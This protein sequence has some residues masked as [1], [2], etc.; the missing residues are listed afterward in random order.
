MMKGNAGQAGGKRSIEET[1]ISIFSLIS[2]CFGSVA[3][4]VGGL[5]FLL[6]VKVT[7][8]AQLSKMGV[9]LEAA[10]PLDRRIWTALFSIAMT[11]MCLVGKQRNI[12]RINR[13][14]P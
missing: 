2:E 1:D 6:I 5:L 3:G 4:F 10:I 9:I 7:F 13:K 14:Q 11:T 8:V 12:E